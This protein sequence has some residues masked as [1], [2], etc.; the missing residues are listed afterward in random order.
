MIKC[1]LKLIYQTNIE[2]FF[3]GIKNGEQG[4]GTLLSL[5]KK[6]QGEWYSNNWERGKHKQRLYVLH[7]WYLILT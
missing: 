3:D 2:V 7:F 1:N 5:W 6:I 4:R